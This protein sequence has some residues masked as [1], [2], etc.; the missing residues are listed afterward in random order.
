[1]R[2]GGSTILIQGVPRT[3]PPILTV[4][5]TSADLRHIYAYWTGSAV[6]LISSNSAPTF[7][8]EYGYWVLNVGGVPSYTYLGS[9]VPGNAHLAPQALLRSY[10]GRTGGITNSK[11]ITN[12]AGIGTATLTR[13]TAQLVSL[14]GDM[15][16][17]PCDME[18]EQTNSSAA[19]LFVEFYLNGGLTVTRRNSGHPQQY[20][21]TATNLIIQRGRFDAPALLNLALNCRANVASFGTVRGVEIYGLAQR[22]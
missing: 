3:I 14:P 9:W 8:D 22:L 6:A 19:P 20:L 11:A 2:Y 16:Q 13:C 1:M 12:A 4:Y 18:V 10:Y 21:T 17:F 5:D 7:N 15:L